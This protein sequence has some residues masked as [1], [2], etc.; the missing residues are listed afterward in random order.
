[1]SISSPDWMALE[2]AISGRVV[3]PGTGDYESA[4][5]PFIARFDDLE[6][7]AVVRCATPED[8][9]EV[10]RFARRYAI[11]T[12]TRSGGHSIA[13]FSSTR[14]IVIDVG[15]MRSV[16]VEHGV[17]HI[18]AGTRLVELYETL[19]EQDLTLPS[20]TCPSVGIGGITLGGGF[21]SLGR[22]YG[23]TLDRLLAA[24]IILADGRL[25]E[26]DV[27][28]YADLFWGLRGAGAG[29]FGVVTS[30][31][32]EPV[33]APR[34]TAFQ[35]AWSYAHAADVI[36]AWQGWA[37]TSPDELATDLVLTL[38]DDLAAKPSVEVYGTVIGTERDASELLEEVIQR[39]GADPLSAWH[40][41]LSYLQ[42]TRHLAALSVTN[43]LVEETPSGRVSR[44]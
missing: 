13:G 28:H 27:E 15:P 17:A 30:L 33:P 34:M 18:G 26:C 29:N 5:K 25:I 1:M 14:G 16:A 32:F 44:Q 6:P 35:L 3:M 23:L 7:Q 19:A 10:I 21:G 43:E 24:Q 37:P 4:R 40:S 41:E 2:A 42:T 11:E 36:T 9:A 38:T 8:V 39:V 12:A 22:R 20:G 31:T